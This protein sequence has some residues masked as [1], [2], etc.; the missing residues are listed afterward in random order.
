MKKTRKLLAGLLS[1]AMLSSMVP[2]ALAEETENTGRTIFSWTEGTIGSNS[3]GSFY[4]NSFTDW[5]AETVNVDMSNIDSEEETDNK[6]GKFSFVGSTA[7]TDFLYNNSSAVVDSQGTQYSVYELGF[8]FVTTDN[9]VVLSKIASLEFGA[10]G[11]P[12]QITFSDGAMNFKIGNTTKSFTPMERTLVDAKVYYQYS[13]KFV[14]VVASYTDTDGNPQTFEHSGTATFSNVKPTRLMPFD[15]GSNTNESMTADDAVYMDDIYYK[16]ITDTKALAEQNTVTY[17]SDDEVYMTASEICG[18]MGTIPTIEKD[19]YIFLGWKMEDGEYL[20]ATTAIDEDMTVTADWTEA[21]EVTYIYTSIDKD[22]VS[23]KIS[24]TVGKITVPAAPTR[25]HYTFGGWY[26]ADEDGNPTGEALVS[27]EELTLSGDTTIVAAWE[28][29]QTEDIFNEDFE[30]DEYDTRFNTTVQ[31]DESKQR[32]ESTVEEIDGNKVLKYT[33]KDVDANNFSSNASYLFN[34]GLSDLGVYDTNTRYEFGYKMDV[35]ELADLKLTLFDLQLGINGNG[36]HDKTIAKLKRNYGSDSDRNFSI[37][38]ASAVTG[39][40]ALSDISDVDGFVSVK[41]YM[42]VNRAKIKANDTVNHYVGEID[43]YITYKS[44]STGEYVTEL[45]TTDTYLSDAADTNCTIKNIL[46]SFSAF[47]PIDSGAVSTTVSSS[48]GKDNAEDYEGKAIYL[49]DIYFRVADTEDFQITFDTTAIGNVEVAPISVVDGFATETLPVPV[50]EG[51]L[52]F[53]GWAYAD[54]TEFVNDGTIR[55]NITLVAKAKEAFTV[56]F[57]STGGSEVSPIITEKNS[58]TLPD[59]PTRDGY[60]FIG[61]VD[62]DGNTFDGTGITGNMTVYAVWD[63]KIFIETFDGVTYDTSFDTAT[64]DD[65][66]KQRWE[67][68]V[69]DVDGNKMMKYTI[70]NVDANN[71]SNNSSSIFSVDLSDIYFDTNTRYEFGYKF[72]ASE[73]ENV[74]LTL[75]NLNAA[76]KVNRAWDATIAQWLQKY[77]GTTK[78]LRLGTGNGQNVT[79]S[80]PVADYSDV[81]G[82]ISVRILFNMNKD[83]IVG[84]DGTY[85]HTVGEIDAYVTY[86]SKSTGE[87]VTATVSTDTY[88]SDIGQENEHIK[89][90]LAY[91]SAMEPIDSG[92]VSTTVSSGYGKDNAADYEGKSFYL[93]DVYFMTADTGSYKVSFDCSNLDE[94][95][96][97]IDVVDGYIFEELPTPT[98]SGENAFIGWVYEDGTEFVNDGTISGDVTLKA[99][100]IGAATVTF[101]SNGGSEVAPIVTTTGEITL[102][103]AP[104]KANCTFIGWFDSNGNAFDGTNVSG[105]MTVYAKWDSTIFNEDFNSAE[106]TT[107]LETI[108]TTG[109]WTSSYDE[110]NGRFVWHRDGNATAANGLY[111]T[112][113]LKSG[114]FDANEWYEV[115]YKIDLN[116][117]SYF[118]GQ[119][120]GT[121]VF[122]SKAGQRTGWYTDI[123]MIETERADGDIVIDGMNIGQSSNID[124]Y[125]TVTAQFTPNYQAE[126]ESTTTG[127]AY[128]K[129]TYK[130]VDGYTHTVSKTKE[131]TSKFADANTGTEGLAADGYIFGKQMNE[132][133]GNFENQNVTNDIYVDDVYMSLVEKT[134]TATY[135]GVEG[136][137]VTTVD[138]VNGKVLYVPEVTVDGFEGWY[139]DSSLTVP[140][141]D[142]NNVNLSGDITIYAKVRA[143]KTVSFYLT[144]E[145]FVAGNV[146]ATADTTT[147]AVSTPAAVTSATNTPMILIGW[148][149][150]DEDGNATD[151]VFDA[152]SVYSNMNVVAVWTDNYFRE[153]FEGEEETGFEVTDDAATRWQSSVEGTDENKYMQYTLLTS[154]AADTVYAPFSYTIGANL[155]RNAW[156]ELGYKFDVD[157]TAYINQLMPIEI[158]GKWH[159]SGTIGYWHQNS[160]SA[161]I[162]FLGGTDESGNSK[163]VNITKDD[164]ADFV[165]VK[166]QFSIDPNNEAV[167]TATDTG[168]ARVY[169]S[170]TNATSGTQV[171]DIVYFTFS[172]WA[173][174]ALAFGINEFKALTMSEWSGSTGAE[175]STVRLD[176]VYLMVMPEAPILSF[177]TNSDTVIDSIEADGNGV[178][179]LPANPTKTGYAFAGWFKDAALTI[180]FNGTGVYSDMTVYA[181]WQKT[182]TAEIKPTDSNNISINPTITVEFDSEMNQDT[183]NKSTIKVTR[184]GVALDT[185]SY[186]LAYS[187]NPTTRNSIVTITFNSRLDYAADYTVVVSK[188]I[189]NK[190]GEMAQDYEKTFTTQKLALETT[191]WVVTESGTENVISSAADAEGK[192]IEI[193]FNFSLKASN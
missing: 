97:A 91:F 2:T 32:W 77:S 65:E 59:A 34:A 153:D 118:F 5:T 179:T 113:N 109:R 3:A 28:L 30:G 119:G 134:G 130:D 56:V 58:I 114:T 110:A 44:L 72:D 50:A 18:T 75:F 123:G 4:Q 8:K 188:A 6:A 133:I 163:T 64:Q 137:D 132:H 89:E 51:E 181:R 19:G 173:D 33:L 166:Y 90:R 187:I 54:G 67:S 47:E 38:N 49:D 161:T 52:A 41:V 69:V 184:D 71:F 84:E 189:T 164:V 129:V 92:A 102:P 86:K 162:S 16:E 156:Y 79:G 11:R 39:Q 135:I 98:F 24:P 180:P 140:L 147:N 115:S 101:D 13:A 27:G 131:V 26:V 21:W 192:T 112:D 85:N 144:T 17:V 60:T 88:R 40:N 125:I 149:V 93:D 63:N 15:P 185:A 157:T 76:I 117:G 57:D 169:I 143:T 150:A 167:E 23:E 14:K 126:S 82:L 31:E 73:L 103:D 74:K 176:D 95:F 190:M 53:D 174:D 154:D 141:D 55:S 183:I 48:Y 116:Q 160:G 124:G 105:S 100:V 142:T 87:Y 62:A 20:T 193:K 35:S 120:F 128:V 108:D 178:V 37:N 1:L 68:S 177:V 127:T 45:V 106:H 136:L 78:N 7:K 66:A 46:K 99:K 191:N 148:Y 94:S 168:V 96:D 81:D 111:F 172:N 138:V 43:V 9:N 175:G 122:S 22:T 29:A 139:L 121:R 12:V 10:N 104:T 83:K 151:T 170:Y 25:T 107:G 145:D 152:N 42:N 36:Y 158:Y 155:D 182:A 80:A 70:K 159:G 186:E 171:N 146:L 165:T 61:W